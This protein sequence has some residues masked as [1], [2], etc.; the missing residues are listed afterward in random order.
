MDSSTDPPKTASEQRAD[1]AIDF[2]TRQINTLI[3]IIKQYGTIITDPNTNQ[4]HAR[5]A[6]HKISFFSPP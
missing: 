2:V 4:N 3:S 1:A 5:A 6:K